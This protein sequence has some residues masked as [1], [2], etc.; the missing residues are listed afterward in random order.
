MSIDKWVDGLQAFAKAASVTR[1]GLSLDFS[2]AGVKPDAAVETAVA[3]PSVFRD[4]N[5]GP[6][7]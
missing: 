5:P 7:I 3:K 6:P 2:Q 1:D 4:R